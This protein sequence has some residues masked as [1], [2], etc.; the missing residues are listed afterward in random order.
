MSP[1]MTRQPV[2]RT[3]V[4]PRRGVT[5]PFVCVMLTAIFGG[6]ALAVDMGRMYVTAGE[7]Q[8][9]ADASALAAV[10]WLEQYQPYYSFINDPTYGI[11]SFVRLNRVAGANA[12][13]LTQDIQPVVY[14]PSAN[15]VTPTSWSSSTSAVTVTVRGTPRY[16]F[17][18]VLG[19]TPPQVTRKATAWIANL[20]GATCVRPFALPYT[21]NFEVGIVGHR[22]TDSTYTKQGLVA[23]DY[24]YSGIA[25]LQ[26]QF[27][28]YNSPQG[29]TYTSIPQW[30]KENVAMPPDT[31]TGRIVIGRWMPSDFGGG[32]VLS[33][34]TYAGLPPKSRGCQPAATQVGATVTPI[35]GYDRPT[36]S[37]KTAL[38]NALATGMGQFCNRLG[39]S[40]DA[41]CYDSTGAVGVRARVF[42]SDSIAGGTG[43]F[44][45]RTR[46]V[47]MVRI[48]CYFRS[49]TDV[50]APAYIRD[51]N[52]TASSNTYWTMANTS[53]PST[54]Y[55]GYPAGTVSVVLDGPTNIDMTSDLV[56]GNKPGITQ[57]TFLV[58]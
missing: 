7:A 47:T 51:E 10:R 53:A 49:R 3:L 57:R 28:W 52:S 14:D 2:R 25:S 36:D 5:I 50:C 30:E 4:R 12:Q 24:T 46:E 6:A 1:A 21:R 35:P 55:T 39:N 19:L 13:V 54:A 27:P 44:A 8:A 22:A 29:R 37:A 17:A 23:P 38:L 26:P 42:I 16:V 9:A 11:P 45:L 41:H 15:T 34:P 40:T 20:N 43:P 33:Y 48:M 31:N 18:G 32:G 56:F 58:R